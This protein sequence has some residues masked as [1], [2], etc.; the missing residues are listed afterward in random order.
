MI[1]SGGMGSIEHAIDLLQNVTVDGFN[2]ADFFHYERGKIGDLK[3][4]LL[5]N[6]FEV[7]KMDKPRIGI[8]NYGAG[9][10]GR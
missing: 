9:N 1:V 3:Q 10:T 8:I 2:I 6:N 5:Q 4:S 7:I